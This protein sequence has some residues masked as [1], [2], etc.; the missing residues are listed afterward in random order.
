MT[1]KFIYIPSDN[2]QITPSVEYV[3]WIKCLDT[4]L[5]GQTYQINE[6]SPKLT[7]KKRYYKTLGTSV[8]NS[9]MSH[10]SLHS[11]TGYSEKMRVNKKCINTTTFI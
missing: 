10:P 7:N 3:S 5:N 6:K 11:V 8:I 2:T 9:P 4:L 1:N